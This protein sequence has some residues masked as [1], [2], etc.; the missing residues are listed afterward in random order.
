MTKPDFRFTVDWFGANIAVW[1]Q[2][3][4]S[5]KPL[6]I[7]EIGS[8]EGRAACHLIERVS[9]YGAID[10]VCVDSWA[11]GAEHQMDMAQ[12]E[13]RFDH[14]IA[15][16]QGRAPGARV[17]KVKS[18]S[19]LALVDLLSAEGPGG[20]DMVYVDGSHQAP[21]VLADAVLGFRLLRL[22]GLMAF[23]DYLWS[24]EPPGRQDL[25]NMPKPAIDAFLNLYQRKL[26][27]VLGA[28]LYQIYA[29][30]TAD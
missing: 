14:N 12:V 29:H 16:A 17:R 9:R 20:Y 22:N 19:D 23:D 24:M 28:P 27:I 3:L 1:D 18:R 10:L 30:K 13:E 8:F 2:M 21:D 25:L 6:R 11:G 15:L 7:I 26:R 5:V 4:A